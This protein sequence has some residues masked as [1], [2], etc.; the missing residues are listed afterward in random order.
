M[1]VL[2]DTYLVPARHR[3]ARV[4][5]VTAPGRIIRHRHAGSN[6]S[7]RGH[8]TLPILPRPDATQTFGRAKGKV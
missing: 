5:S 6:I 2:I 3:R 7:R 1:R 8:P 4:A